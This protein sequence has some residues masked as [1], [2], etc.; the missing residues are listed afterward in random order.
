[1]ATREATYAGTATPGATV[2]V[3]AAQ[4]GTEVLAGV[5]KTVAGPDGQ[6]RLTTRPMAAG[7][8]RVVAVSDPKVLHLPF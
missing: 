2:Q 1:M 7:Q 6:W 5:G 8:Y 4:A 3:L